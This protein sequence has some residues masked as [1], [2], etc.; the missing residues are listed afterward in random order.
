MTRHTRKIVQIDEDKCDGCG[1]CVPD[2]AEGAIK[3]VDG[4]ARLL[5]D[6][7]CDGLGN[8]LGSCPRDAISIVE[9]PA[10]DFDEEAVQTHLR[11]E[12]SE[13]QNARTETANEK[14]SGHSPCGCPGSMLRQ[15]NA[16]PP[17]ATAGSGAQATSAR[18]SQL[19]HWPVQLALLPPGSPVWA[20]ADVLLAADCVP[21]AMPDFHERLLSGK[22]LAI[23]CPK[24]D[25]PEP[26][27]SKLADIFASQ[28]IKSITIARMEVPCCGGLE[29]IVG[30]AME[31]ANVKIPLTVVIVS[32]NGTMLSVNGLQ[33]AP[34]A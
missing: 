8:C 11:R 1:V 33:L 18:P 17:A 27:V 7:L 31:K 13:A 6:N 5:A 26:Y 32:A 34:G 10:V 2:C 19:R 15:F 24:L 22:T 23:A 12:K 30:L 4:K 20:D 25:N 9:R 21:F 28:S 3:I 14:K 29:H 16:P